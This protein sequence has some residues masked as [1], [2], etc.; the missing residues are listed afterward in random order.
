M[1]AFQKLVQKFLFEQNRISVADVVRLLVTLGYK[2]K[3][4]PGS[5][6]VFHKKGSPVIP[7]PT[8]SGRYLKK[9]YIT[10]LVKNLELERYVEEG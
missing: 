2:E 1:S 3:K 5:H 4:N 10:L 7:I 8:I 6:R 9:K